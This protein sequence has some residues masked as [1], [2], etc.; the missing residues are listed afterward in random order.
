MFNYDS[1]ILR[2]SSICRAWRASVAMA[3]QGA[4]SVTGR[5]V[6]VSVLSRLGCQQLFFREKIIAGAKRCANRCR[7]SKV[8]LLQVE[9]FQRAGA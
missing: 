2:P 3:R 7:Q 6:G 1:T 4:E 9:K 5:T 8:L